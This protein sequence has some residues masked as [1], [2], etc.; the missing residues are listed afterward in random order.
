MEIGVNYTPRDGW[1]HSWLDLDPASVSAD[2]AAIAEAGL[3]HVRVFPLWP[4]LQ[5]N[6]TMIR[7]R[8]IEDVV[9]VVDVAAEHGLDVHVDAINGHLSSYDFLPSWVTTWHARDLFCD[10]EVVAAQ[11]DLLRRLGE[12][13][14]E[15]PNA[16]GIGLGNEI[17]QFASP[18]HPAPSQPTSDDVEAWLSGHFAALAEVWAD[19]EHSHSFDDSLWF[20]DEHAFQ[21]RHAVTH[22]ATTTVHSWVFTGAGQRHGHGSPV[23]TRYA[24]YLLEVAAGWQHDAGQPDRPLW[25]QEVGAPSTHVPAHAAPQFARYTLLACADMPG[26]ARVTWWCS[27]D[28]ARSAADF[29][30]L[31]YSLGLFG[32]DGRRK[33]I[34]D[35]VADLVPQLRA[36][37]PGARSGA[38]LEYDVDRATG[39]GRATAGPRGE[40]FDRWQRAFAD[41]E[42]LQ[43]RPRPVPDGPQR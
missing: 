18:G 26:L 22:G 6:R 5:P 1:F 9:R 17:A 30:E 10:P 3:D 35:A 8:A 12:A 38:V 41:G 29:P 2:L 7:R 37:S 39:R 4:L 33:P 42:V 14:A 28:V 40:V 25:L 34:G 32:N 31:E 43:V 19:G 15:R 11:R 13:L 24:R 23:L 36:A 16:R 21:P 20:L 27:H